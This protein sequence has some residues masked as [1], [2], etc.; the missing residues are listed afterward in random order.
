[1]KKDIA[2]KKNLG[3]LNEFLKYSFANPGVLEKI[4]PGAELIILPLDDPEL[5]AY[6]RKTAEKILSLGKK[7]VL[8]RIKKSQALPPDLELLSA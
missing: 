6:N 2:V 3:L 8:A 4:P 1:M 5:S 7:V